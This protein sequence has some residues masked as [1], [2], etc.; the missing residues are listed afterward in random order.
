MGQARLRRRAHCDQVKIK[1]APQR[2]VGRSPASSFPFPIPWT[3]SMGYTPFGGKCA[4]LDQI[5][6]YSDALATIADAPVNSPSLMFS[7]VMR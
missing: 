1:G 6:R 7:F 3:N 5:R 2:A 4:D